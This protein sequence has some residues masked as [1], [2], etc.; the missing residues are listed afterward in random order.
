MFLNVAKWSKKT[1]EILKTGD[2]SSITNFKQKRESA[3]HF[4]SFFNIK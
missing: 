2:F 3:T 1:T 4:F